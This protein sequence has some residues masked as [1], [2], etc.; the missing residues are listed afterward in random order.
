MSKTTGPHGAGTYINLP[1]ILIL[2]GLLAFGY[3]GSAD[4]PF[5]KRGDSYRLVSTFNTSDTVETACQQAND[6]CSRR[7]VLHDRPPNATIDEF[8]TTLN[9]SETVTTSSFEETLIH[10][11]YT[12][13]TRSN[14]YSFLPTDS[15]VY[16]SCDMAA[17]PVTEL[18]RHDNTIA[19][20]T[21]YDRPGC[22]G[23]HG[24]RQQYALWFWIGTILI[25]IGAGIGLFRRIRN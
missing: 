23:P 25:T 4:H 17:V 22:W 8:A 12:E 3:A 13:Y 10:G 1:T 24:G 7:S 18:I 2:A 20:I 15:V 6:L 9:E 11:R 14:A 19:A 5:D 16:A 21:V